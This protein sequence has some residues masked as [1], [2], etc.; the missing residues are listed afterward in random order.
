[1]PII[2]FFHA[3]S[4]LTCLGIAFHLWQYRKE[5]PLVYNFSLN[6][7]FFGLYFLLIA[8]PGLFIY[9]LVKIYWLYTF[10]NLVLFVTLALFIRIPLIIAL[11][12][13]GKNIVPAILVFFGFLV[14]FLR[15]F[16]VNPV[17][18]VFEGNAFFYFD[19]FPLFLRVFIGLVSGGVAL[20]GSLFFFLNAFQVDYWKMRLRSILF[21]T[22]F[23]ALFASGLFNFITQF[24]SKSLTMSVASIFAI[25]GMILVF[26]G[27]KIQVAS[28]DKS[29]KE[30]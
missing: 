29:L 28:E 2:A 23:L 26:L 8:A 24:P 22:G 17:L 14:V 20:T 9:D 3:I 25:S 27:M 5:S 10:A 21:G 19:N 12:G 18:I 30:K 6:F 1:M 7:W 4:F 11:D 13:K 15:I 16:F